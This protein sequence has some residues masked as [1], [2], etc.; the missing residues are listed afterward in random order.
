[1]EIKAT[2]NKPYTE[3]ERINF[4]LE[5]NRKYNY[6]I[7]S[8][9]TQLEAWGYTDEEKEEQERER[10][11]NLKCTKRVLA[12]ILQQLGIQYSQL[13]SLIDSNE[14]AQLEWDLCVE[15]ERSNPLIN[16]VGAELRLTPTDIDNIFKYANGEISTIQKEG[17]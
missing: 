15:L 2:L 8:S 4:I 9:N 14:Q 3:E 16:I 7:K 11:S 10:V 12:L 1:M 6:V 17:E 13:K 5:Y